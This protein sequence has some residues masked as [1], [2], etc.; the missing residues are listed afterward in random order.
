MDLKNFEST[1][2]LAIQA[3]YNYFWDL[4]PEKYKLPE[5][6]EKAN[7]LEPFYDPLLTFDNRLHYKLTQV[8]YS[9]RDKPWFVITWNTE[10]GLIPSTF[11]RRR[12]QS[13][14]V[15]N[16]KLGPLRF[17]FINTELNINLAIC[18]N[19]MVGLY[20]LQENIVLKIR[21]KQYTNTKEHSILG[22]F[23][24]SLN[25]IDSQQSKLDRNKGT[26][27]YLN[28]QV[29]VD[30]PIIECV[31]QIP[32]G[33]IK[34]IHSNVISPYTDE[35]IQQDIVDHQTTPNGYDVYTLGEGKHRIN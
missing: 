33:I 13:A 21:D 5:D 16:K 30:Y 23:P 6:I 25:V 1:S 3:V 18:G 32:N 34:E 12:Y 28:L 22:S 19:T 10:N 9:K 11:N 15:D 14:I 20:E 35:S 26:L 31:Q 24:V 4:I 17:K 27:C 7:S 2:V 8:E 29:K